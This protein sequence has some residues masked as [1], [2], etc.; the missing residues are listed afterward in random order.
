MLLKYIRKWSGLKYITGFGEI[1][2]KK[3]KKILELARGDKIDERYRK[4]LKINHPD[5]GG[6]EFIANKINE[7]RKYLL[8]KESWL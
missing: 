8:E 2:T 6:S 1:N 3:S 4:L 7:A 5:L